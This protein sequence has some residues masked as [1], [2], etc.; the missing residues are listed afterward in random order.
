M[1]LI[2]KIAWVQ[3]ATE[4]VVVMVA[5][6]MAYMCATLLPVSGCSCGQDR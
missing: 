6:N 3:T 2:S 1:C 5:K 4:Y